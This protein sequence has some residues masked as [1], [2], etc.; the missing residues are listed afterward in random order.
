MNA[1]ALAQSPQRLDTLTARAIII[2][3]TLAAIV[4]PLLIA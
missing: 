4:V 3:T 1:P 2:A